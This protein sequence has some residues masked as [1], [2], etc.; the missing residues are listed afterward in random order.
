MTNKKR[1]PY[2]IS[3]ENLTIDFFFKVVHP[4]TISPIDPIW[5]KNTRG[6]TFSSWKNVQPPHVLPIIV[7]FKRNAY[8]RNYAN[9]IVRNWKKKPE[10]LPVN[11]IF[12]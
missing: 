8:F 5:T 2:T 6:L 4:H 10:N 7:I 1:S 9:W 11:W 12:H 3:G